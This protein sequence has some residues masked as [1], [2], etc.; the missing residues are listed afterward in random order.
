V[1]DLAWA[2]KMSH[3]EHNDHFQP[4]QALVAVADIPELIMSP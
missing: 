1:D 2:P 4:V 3:V